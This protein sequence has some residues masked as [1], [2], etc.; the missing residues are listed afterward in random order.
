MSQTGMGERARPRETGCAD[1]QKPIETTDLTVFSLPELGAARR[2][3]RLA[4]AGAMK[5]FEP[6]LSCLSPL[7]RERNRRRSKFGTLVVSFHI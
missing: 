7:F 5:F 4:E 2:K 3:F 1:L 6:A